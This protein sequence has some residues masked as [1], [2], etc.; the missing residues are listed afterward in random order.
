[1]NK[2]I[3]K[4]DDLED[5]HAIKRDKKRTKKNKQTDNRKSIFTL[6]KLAITK[7]DNKKR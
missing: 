2:E 1:M 4:F 5:T 3:N 6:E 7:K